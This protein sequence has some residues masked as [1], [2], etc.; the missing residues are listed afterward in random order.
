MSKRGRVGS[1]GGKFRI[2]LGLPVG[3]VINCSNDTGAKNLK[4]EM[5]GTAITGPVAKECADLWPRSASN[6]SSIA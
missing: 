4:G 5:N 2:S 3:V 1:A 6:S